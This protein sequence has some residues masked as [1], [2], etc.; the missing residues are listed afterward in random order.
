[1]HT[2]MEE[3]SIDEL[4]LS[5]DLSWEMAWDSSA[6]ARMELGASDGGFA[7]DERTSKWEAFFS[8]HHWTIPYL[9]PQMLEFTVNLRKCRRHKTFIFI[10]NTLRISLKMGFLLSQMNWRKSVHIFIN[11]PMYFSLGSYRRLS[12]FRFESMV[13]GCCDCCFFLLSDSWHHWN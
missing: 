7:F 9:F 3:Q 2:S 12:R 10:W 8:G 11:N 1:M 6:K 5:L 4:C 13:S